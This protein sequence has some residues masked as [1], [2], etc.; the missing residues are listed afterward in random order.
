MK[1]S[2][3]VPVRNSA[4]YMEK[5]LLSLRAQTMGDFEAL[6]ID[7]D[8]VDATASIAQSWQREDSRFRYI[9]ARDVP[10]DMWGK[11]ETMPLD[12]DIRSD[13]GIKRNIGIALSRAPYMASLD[14]D[15][16]YD[17]DMLETLCNGITGK[18]ADIAVC[19]FKRVYP[20][21]T[22]PGFSR[23]ED[24]YYPECDPIDYYYKHIC[25]IK[26]NNFMWTRL[27]RVDYLKE[28]KLRVPRI[29]R[30]CDHLF[31]LIVGMTR[32]NMAHIAGSPYNYMQRE[33][34]VIYIGARKRGQ[35]KLFLSMLR[36]TREHLREYPGQTD[37]I[38][39]IYAYTRVKSLL[40]YGRLMRMEKAQTLG[41]VR[42]FLE[43]EG[44]R[45]CLRAV[46]DNGDFAR[47][48]SLNSI[49]GGAADAMNALLI[50]CVEGGN[51]DVRDDLPL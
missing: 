15:D 34:S 1:V 12:S 11:E 47:Y 45:E 10:E 7:S 8:S 37:S 32:P 19:D 16:T 18:G 49:T 35:G 31:N 26:P 44:V 46:R 29:A 27:F 17:P 24:A 2:V 48:C 42:E 50:S 13:E 22:L 39:G 30:G 33:D 5:C 9:N 43:D 40:F 14:S 41:E 6:L 21:R 51:L 38:L 23:I 4:E 20:D 36:I 25:G 28:K 3:I